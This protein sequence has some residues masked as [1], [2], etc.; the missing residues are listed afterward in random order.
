VAPFLKWPECCPLA[1]GSADPAYLA[2]S[3]EFRK[4]FGPRGVMHSFGDGKI[5]DTGP[6]TRKRKE[7]VDQEFLNAALDFIDRQHK[8]EAILLLLQLDAH[9]LL[10]ELADVSVVLM[11]RILGF[12]SSDCTGR[13]ASI[14]SASVP[15]RCQDSDSDEV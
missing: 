6:L 5:E 1:H 3:P 15:A 10:R 2:R 4:R 11:T 12:F 7:T 8:A 13:A 9:A 14:T